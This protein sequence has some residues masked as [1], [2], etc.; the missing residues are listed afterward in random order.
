MKPKDLQSPYRW[1]ARRP[2]FQDNVL[3]VPDYYDD[4]AAFSMP[5]YKEIFGNDHPVSIEYCSGNGEWIVQMACQHPSV[6]WIACE[7]QF[8]RVRKIWSKRQNLGINN[9][10]IVCGEGR[11]FTRYYLPADSIDTVYVNYPDPWPKKR[12]AKHRIIQKPFVDELKRIC[13]KGARIT[14]VT[15]DQSYANQM[16][17]EMSGWSG[18]DSQI[19]RE[20]HGPSF[21][22]RLWRSKGREIQKLEYDY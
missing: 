8:K 12:H 4:H 9:L 22:D 6:N 5:T 13:K 1:D 3:F 18:P 7:I 15:D 16:K 19:I 10:L 17:M 21:F 14:Y 2:L 20:S 11:A